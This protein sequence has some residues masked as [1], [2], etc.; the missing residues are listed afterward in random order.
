MTGFRTKDL[1]ISNGQTKT[2]V[3]PSEYELCLGDAAEAAARQDEARRN[4][5]RAS[6]LSCLRE[7]RE[8]RVALRSELEQ[9][10]AS[11]KDKIEEQN[12]RDLEI[13][14]AL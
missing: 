8:H 14:K 5:R 1:E 11:V 10:R 13:E 7:C 6:L 2:T 4:E 3:T 12:T 9:A